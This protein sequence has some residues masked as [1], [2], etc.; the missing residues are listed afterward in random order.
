MK[1]GKPRVR[2]STVPPRMDTLAKKSDDVTSPVEN[3]QEGQ[4]I[5]PNTQVM[6]CPSCGANNRVDR[7]KIEQG[8]EPVCGD[9]KSVV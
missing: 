1:S 4:N 6:R 8:N 3:Y 5:M 2:N 7:E 9:R